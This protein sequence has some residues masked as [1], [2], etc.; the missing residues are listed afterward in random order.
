MDAACSIQKRGWKSR[1]SAGADGKPR[2][3]GFLAP[4]QPL[5]PNAIRKRR[6]PH[7]GPAREGHHSMAAGKK[8]DNTG[9]SVSAQEALEFHSMGRPGKLEINPTKPMAT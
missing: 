8:P 9:P 1:G 3:S 7:P 6:G 4:V 2:K 5:F